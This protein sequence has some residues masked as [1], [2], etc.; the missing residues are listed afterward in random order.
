MVW[1]FGPNYALLDTTTENKYLK[2]SSGLTI[3]NVTNEDEGQY[4]CVVGNVNPLEAFISLTVTCKSYIYITSCYPI[5]AY[6]FNIHIASVTQYI[7][8]RVY[9]SHAKTPSV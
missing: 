2:N 4:V 6:C 3:Y 9:I 5:D 1:E 7:A 8:I